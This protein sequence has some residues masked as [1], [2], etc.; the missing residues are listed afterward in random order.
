MDNQT[1]TT[2][3]RE[4]LDNLKPLHVYVEDQAFNDM[5]SS[6]AVYW[7]NDCTCKHCVQA[8]TD[9][10]TKFLA[11]FD[12]K[13]KIKTKDIIDDITPT[14]LSTETGSKQEYIKISN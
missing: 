5:N 13:K 3:I 14:S 7:K 2:E 1:D 11:K 6:Q 4:A 8:I 12:T 9:F 10:K